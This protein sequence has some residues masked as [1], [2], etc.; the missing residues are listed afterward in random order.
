[1]VV[2]IPIGWGFKAALIIFNPE[3]RKKV[4]AISGDKSWVKIGL[5]RLP[6][7]V[8]FYLLAIYS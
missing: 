8:I 2:I 3:G 1:M 4:S 7:A 6:I 5:A